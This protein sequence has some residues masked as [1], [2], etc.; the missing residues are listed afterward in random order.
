MK[1]RNKF[2]LTVVV[3][4]I[5]PLS[6]TFLIAI[7]NTQDAQTH[8][9]LS[10]LSTVASIQKARVE[11]IVADYHQMINNIASKPRATYLK[12]YLENT[13]IDLQALAYDSLSS[14]CEIVLMVEQVSILST[15]GIVLASS[16]ATKLGLDLSGEE[17]VIEG[18]IDHVIDAF[19]IDLNETLK[20]YFAGPIIT[21][22]TT[23][24]L[25]L[26]EYTPSDLIEV[27][28]DYTG[29]GNTGESLIAKRDENGDALF[30]STLR[31]QSQAT[32]NLT[33]SKDDLS[34]PI[35]QALL[36]IEDTYTVA[37]DYL[38]H[39]VIAVTR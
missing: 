27:F 19:Y 18:L 2:T 26:I 28:Q 38:D 17:Y 14:L 25:V 37:Y 31:H 36:G 24:G 5:L 6:F 33:L 34:A 29:F 23:I 9:I 22:E 4:A 13:S 3:L 11:E 15:D 16:N 7:P 30:I 1:I 32:L 8:Q 12:A 39:P 35:T 10:H 21:N 20:S